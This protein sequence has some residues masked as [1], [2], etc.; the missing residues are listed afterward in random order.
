MT[1]GRA[2]PGGVHRAQNTV[3]STASHSRSTFCALCAVH[4]N[5]SKVQLSYNPTSCQNHVP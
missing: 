5:L 1:A 3:N 4:Y 2:A